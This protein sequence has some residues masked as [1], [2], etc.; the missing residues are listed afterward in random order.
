LKSIKIISEKLRARS[1]AFIYLAS[2]PV[3]YLLLVDFDSFQMGWNQ[4][5]GG[6]IIA[7]IFLVLEFMQS[8]RSLNQN[9]SRRRI[10]ISLVFLALL[11]TY[12]TLEVFY[13]LQ[14]ALWSVGTEMNIPLLY[15]WVWISDYLGLAIYLTLSMIVILGPSALRYLTSGVLYLT[16]TAIILGLDAFFPY[17][18]LGPLQSFV[19][20]LLEVDSFLLGLLGV[21]SLISGNILTLEG[22][23]GPFSIAVFWP[24]AGVHSIIIYSIVMLSFLI[25]IDMSW[26]RRALYFTIGAVGTVGV[27]IIRVFLLSSYLV[28]ITSDPEAF[29]QFHAVAGEILFLPW[30]AIY[31]TLIRIREAKSGIEGISMQGQVLE[32]V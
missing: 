13:E 4:G 3:I 11:I 20:I 19:P 29:E 7:M 31:L 15:S 21:E 18:T 8:R 17:S 24:S 5:R 25:K 26:H 28:F 12:F 10:L 14:D 6:F 2:T 23:E 16:A 22:K 32:K 30:L 9:L 27:N 1:F